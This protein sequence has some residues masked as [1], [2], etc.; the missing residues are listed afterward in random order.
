[1]KKK[2][3]KVDASRLIRGLPKQILGKI[4]EEEKVDDQVKHLYG[5]LMLK[6]I[7]YSHF[8]NSKLSTRILENYY[9]SVEFSA[10]TE[11]G[12]H[13]T[14]HSSIAD[15]LKN[16]NSDYFKDIF[17]YYS[18]ELQTKYSNKNK[19]IK[20]IQRFDSTMVAISAG[21]INW[22]MHVGR[23]LKKDEGKVQ[24]KFTI[25]LRGL[26]PTDIK[27]H[28]TQKYISEDLALKE[29]IEESIFSKD[30]IAVFDRGLKK[31]ETFDDF[32][33]Q[34]QYFVTRLNSKCNYEIIRT[35]KNIKGRRAGNLILEKDI[36]VRLQKSG[37]KSAT[38]ELRLI[39]AKDAKTGET[40]IILTNIYEMTTKLI[41][42]IYKSRWD[43]E[44]FFRFLKQELNFDNITPYNENGIMVMVYVSMIAA[45]MILLY[46]ELNKIEGYRIAKLK[47]IE[48]IEREVY[49]H[50]IVKCG[51]DVKTFKRVYIT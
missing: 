33:N 23:K 51:G 5:E 18:N 21:F 6:L 20:T 13:E 11:K 38:S 48:D 30:S 9:N 26:F 31:R 14:R 25:G 34:E 12:K 35:H 37:G 22:G 27:M 29:A 40:I 46:K 8:K 39:I 4:A 1:M 50:L 32:S 16:I 44:V 3:H 17:N 45:M 19:E 28:H 47:F 24:L 49:S 2:G 42:E 43:I 7:L 10:L 41:T 15:R 36:I